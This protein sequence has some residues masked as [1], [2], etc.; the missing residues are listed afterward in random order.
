MLRTSLCGLL[1]LAALFITAMPVQACDSCM[2][3]LIG[4][5]DAV[6]GEQGE[7][8]PYFVD[9]LFEQQQWDRIDAAAAHRLHHQGH[10]LHVKTH[11]EY[12]HLQAGMNLKTNFSVFADLPYVSRGSVEVDEHA[13]LGRHQ[14]SEGLGDLNLVTVWKFVN[15]SA[16]FVGLT[17]G[18]KLP[19][20]VTDNEKPDRDLVEAAAVASGSKLESD[21][22]K[23][24]V[25]L[26]PGSGSYD[27]PLGGV[28]RY[29]ADKV[30]LKGN[31]VYIIK[32][33][34]AREFEFG[35]LFTTSL[36]VETSLNPERERGRIN[37]GMDLNYQHEGKHIDHGVASP[38]SGGDLLLA[39]PAV[40]IEFT[41][42]SQ[43]YSTVLFP[44]YQNMGG[45][46]QELDL[47][48]TAG[49]RINW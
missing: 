18:I 25:E 48:W 17:G 3:S 33:R 2:C 4:R 14:T 26:Q 1:L 16:G 28:F 42:G 41:P 11:E 49:G 9:F 38:D 7:V 29:H 37:V 36:V 12:Y 21:W 23:Y 27:F 8:K 39:G 45:V 20:G 19:T 46:H 44:V 35:D 40:T 32:T 30:T 10:H 15:G 22:K 31:A 24:E 6:S 43:F 5:R 13:R 34:G 47:M